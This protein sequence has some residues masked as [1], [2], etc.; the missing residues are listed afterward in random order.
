MARWVGEKGFSQRYHAK[1]NQADR[2][3]H[4]MSGSSK[5]GAQMSEIGFCFEAE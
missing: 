3:N 5:Q 2:I 4:L 1:Q